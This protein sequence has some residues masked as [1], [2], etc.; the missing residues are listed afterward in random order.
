MGE[1]IDSLHSHLSIEKYKSSEVSLQKDVPLGQSNLSPVFPTLSS[2]ILSSF[3]HPSTSQT[4]KDVFPIIPHRANRRRNSGNG[5]Y[6]PHR[7][8]IRRHTQIGPSARHSSRRIGNCL[9]N[10]TF[11]RRLCA[12]RSSALQGNRSNDGPHGS[13]LPLVVP[14]CLDG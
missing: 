13:V 5:R 6:L 8:R 2:S 14:A 12:T 1:N 7:L 9:A 3:H 4:A 10:S 11:R